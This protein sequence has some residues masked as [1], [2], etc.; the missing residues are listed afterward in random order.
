[1][2]AVHALIHHL[3]PDSDA[4]PLPCR[5]LSLTRFSTSLTSATLRAPTVPRRI[6]EYLRRAYRLISPSRP[7]LLPFPCSD[8]GVQRFL[9]HH[10]SPII[11][12][13]FGSGKKNLNRKNWCSAL[14]LQDWVVGA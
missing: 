7:P 14:G 8:L 12:A 5:R 3:T 10:V 1:M 6:G 9:V 2:W 4:N 13:V 11:D